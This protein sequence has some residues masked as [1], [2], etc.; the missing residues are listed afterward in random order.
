M[1]RFQRITQTVSLALFLLLVYM[2]SHPYVQGV[3]TDLFLR[4]DPSIGLLSSIADRSLIS[5]ALIPSLVLVLLTLAFGRFFCGH[6]CPMGIVIDTAGAVSC[7]K[8]RSRKKH[9]SYEETSAY[10]KYKYF[11]LSFLLFCSFGGVSLVFL[12]SPISLATR[13]FALV[14]HPLTLLIADTGLEMSAPFNHTIPQLDYLQV[15]VRVFATNEFLA[16]FFLAVALL[17]MTQSRF[18]CRN[19]CPTG[20]ILAIFSVRPLLKRRVNDSCIHCNKCV[21]ECPTGSITT[22]HASNVSSECIVCLKCSSACP[23]SAVS[24]GFTSPKDASTNKVMLD[25]PFP[26]RRQ[27]IAGMV[28][29]LTTAG[30]I[31][32]GW[33]QPKL[34]GQEKSLTDSELIRPPGALPE[35]DFLSRCVRCGQCMKACPTNTLQPIWLKAGIEGMFSPVLVP[36]LAACELN[37][38]TCGHVCPTAAIRPLDILEKK[39]V[40]IGTA[41]IDRRACLVWNRDRKC[42]VC[43]EVCPYNAVVFKPEVGHGNAVPYVVANKCTGCGWCENKC[44]IEG[45][46][47]IRINIIGEVRLKSGSYIEKAK[48]YGL[49]FKTDK[50]EGDVLAPDTFDIRDDTPVSNRPNEGGPPGKEH[51]LPAGFTE[52]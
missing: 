6:V 45:A 12:G 5:S 41:W 14:I 10:R 30:I 31:R 7:G 46:S 43:D 26:S 19:L 9:N 37:C 20:A 8:S 35:R 15:P 42:L 2:A 17:S 50:A 22:D 25:S 16:L 48:E 4:I 23:V 28:T 40:K 24:F 38:A 39:S 34:M 3:P 47:A 52:E 36:R 21:R 27:A 11:F 51:R 18:W 32:T 13:F 33:N 29:G 1:I 49:E 44:P